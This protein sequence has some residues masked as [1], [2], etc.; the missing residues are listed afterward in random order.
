MNTIKDF[1][2][3]QQIHKTYVNMVSNNRFKKIVFSLFQDSRYFDKF[4]V[5]I[6]FKKK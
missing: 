1:Y 4:D 2:N 3:E 6:L 5:L